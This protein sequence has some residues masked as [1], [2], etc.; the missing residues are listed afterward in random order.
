MEERE[1]VV[2]RRLLGAVKTFVSREEQGGQREKARRLAGWR[3][4]E[5]TWLQ[6]TLIPWAFVTLHTDLNPEPPVS[7]LDT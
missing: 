7:S 4:S 6:F 2:G 3:W 1:A 5:M